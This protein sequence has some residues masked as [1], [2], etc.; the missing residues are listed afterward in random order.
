MEVH[1]KAVHSWRELLSEIGVIV[2]GVIIALGAEQA[3]EAIHW[4]HKVADAEEAM[5]RE[6]SNNLG[7][8]AG[9]MAL[10]NCAAK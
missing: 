7:F 4:R 5:S 3:V 10:K 8:A 9:Q 6:L 1:A 2:I